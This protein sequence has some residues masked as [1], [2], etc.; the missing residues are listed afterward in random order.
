VAVV[1]RWLGKKKR[2]SVRRATAAVEMAVVTPF[3]LTL[4]FGIIEFGWVFSVRQ[5]LVTA[6]REGARTAALPGSEVADVQARIEDFL[7]PMGLV[8]KYHWE[9]TRASPETGDAEVV[10]LWVA[11]QDVT[12]VGQ[13]FGNPDYNLTAVCSMRKEVVE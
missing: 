6:A 8:S 13:W 7:R 5:A 11:Y 12:L 2:T 9:L 4:L 3:L 1:N 10:R